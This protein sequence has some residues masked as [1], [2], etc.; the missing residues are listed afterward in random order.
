MAWPTFN[1]T[2]GT[3]P[4]TQSPS[5]SSSAKMTPM[6]TQMVT[7]SIEPTTC[8]LIDVVIV[9]DWAPIQSSW[10]L[11]RISAF[12]DSSLV[13]TYEEANWIARS[14]TESM[15]LPAGEYEFTIYDSAGDGICCDWGDG[16]YNVTSV[17]ELIA[18]GGDFE[19]KETTIFS[20]PFISAP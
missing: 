6:P 2:T 11:Q 9:Y 16:H 7:L 18:Q 13:K 1:P 17:G 20:I 19:E 5:S 3:T 8:Y 15:C 12:G 10:T 14:Y 4:Q